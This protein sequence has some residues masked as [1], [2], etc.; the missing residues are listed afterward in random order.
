MPLATSK[1]MLL[2]AQ[3]GGYAVGAFNANNMEC[4][5]AVIEAAEEENAPVI[6]QVS[7][8]AIKYAGLEMATAMVRAAAERAA[9][10]VALHLDHG[11]SFNQNVQCLI[12]G[13]TSLMYDGHEE[14]LE[15]NIEISASIAKIGR[16]AGVP[17]ECELGTI[18]K[19]E[20]YFKEDEIA[21]LRKKDVPAAVAYV[22]E[23]AGAKVASLMADPKQAKQFV[24]GTGTDT[25]A[26]AVGSIHGMWDDI[27]PLRIDRI[28]EVRDAT[29][30]PLVLHGSSG[31]VRTRADAEKRGIKLAANEG[32]L[33]DAV[34]AGISKVNVATAVSMA[35]LAGA[36]DAFAKRPGERDLRK[37]LLPGLEAAKALVKSYIQQLG[38]SGKA[39][40]NAAGKKPSEKSV[41]MHS[42]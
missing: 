35:F 41:V 7:Q 28:K 29:D 4:V 37:I 32:T 33:E 10:P 40:V 24:E 1:E 25:L 6:L 19:V 11:T 39:E 2:A 23:K 21:E 30:R 38:S 13:F 20:D 9:V 17:L 14:T 5:K 31:I 15:K 18:P 34:K 12:A 26:A 36:Q 27:W 8:G 16:L 42:E 3:K 22:R